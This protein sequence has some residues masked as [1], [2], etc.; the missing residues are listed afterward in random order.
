MLYKLK[1][2]NV[3][4]VLGLCPPDPDR[5]SSVCMVLE[6]TRHG[7]LRR[8]LRQHVPEDGSISTGGEKIL[9]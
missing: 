1:D 9:R 5:S 6:Y 3:A 2:P 7:D 4:A 8:F